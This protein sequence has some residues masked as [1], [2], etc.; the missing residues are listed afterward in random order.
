M[1]LSNKA[2]LAL[3]GISLAMTPACEDL[4]NVLKPINNIISDET[5]YEK[6]PG[7]EASVYLA[8]T[9]G[10]LTTDSSAMLEAMKVGINDKGTANLLDDEEYSLE[11][12][13]PP[14]VSDAALA[15]L[16]KIR[17]A[18]KAL[19]PSAFVI[20]DDSVLNPSA[21]L[22]LADKDYTN[23]T[24]K[25][26]VDEFTIPVLDKM[27]VRNQGQRGTCAA[28]SGIGQIEGYLL[29][30][31][32][33]ES[34]DLSE[35]RFY[36]MS[37]PK[38]WGDGG[39]TGGS[40]AGDGFAVS[41]TIKTDYD[42]GYPDPS[43]FSVSNTYNLPL[44]SKCPYNL[45]PGDNEIQ[46]P[47]S[48][49][50]DCTSGVAQVISFESWHHGYKKGLTIDSAQSIYD[51]VVN[52]KYPVVVSS[53]LSKNWEKNDGIIT[54]A[55]A[56]AEGSTE[57]ASGH[58]YLVVGVRKLD[59]AKYPN[60]GG[61]CFIIKNSWGKGWGVNGISCMTLAWFNH[62]RSKGGLP[63]V[64][65]VKLDTQAVNAQVTASDKKP[66]NA[67]PP[68][69]EKPKTITEDNTKTT[70]KRPKGRIS[71][72]LPERRA[73]LLADL[74]YA[75]LVSNDDEFRKVL[76]RVEDEMFYLRGVLAGE[77]QQTNDL[78]LKID[79]AG[80][81][82]KN[83][84]GKGDVVVGEINIAQG[85]L[86]LCSQEYAEKCVFNYLPDSNEILVAISEAEFLRDDSEG[87]FNWKYF[88][89][90]GNGFEV[91]VP[92]GFSTKLDVRFSKSG[93]T[94]NPLRFRIDP[95]GGEIKYLGITIGNYQSAELCS[96]SFK[97]IC[98]IV[99]TTE[100]FL[101]VFK[102]Q[103]KET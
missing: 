47:G 15:A 103:P 60:E 42:A 22:A 24:V 72:A 84:P 83:F 21:S 100:K 97:P 73:W 25:I 48:K 34:I 76:Y 94:T 14:Q 68:D 98:S 70:D 31:S 7:S 19:D 55:D 28:F 18:K 88:G 44:E 86:K 99:R 49:S 51:H 12:S 33:L 61:M 101:V 32:T 46:I 5:I 3:G 38:S 8:K 39:T 2:L 91:S 87:P 93:V 1:H 75:K 20:I 96:G 35:Q 64:K 30:N 80:K 9:T 67:N 40:N 95:I 13:E 17:A 74:S 79:S 81:L 66:E 92:D 50:G 89:V 10:N 59:E 63:L 26:T 53:K 82:I 6:P 16:E 23:D 29:Q 4:Q 52:K 69:P 11:G 27:P 58:A 41:S 90:G 45:K 65:E 78:S 77:T 54:W 56:Q 85:I 36:A 71:F 62:F 57:H 37:K 102:S 43:T